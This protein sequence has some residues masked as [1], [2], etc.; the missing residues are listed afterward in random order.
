MCSVYSLFVPFSQAALI[1]ML[2]SN[3]VLQ[4]RL[5]LWLASLL[6]VLN[7]LL[8]PRAQGHWGSQTSCACPEAPATR[9]A[10]TRRPQTSASQGQMP[11]IL[12]RA[13]SRAQ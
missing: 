5:G 4:S 7:S 2:H 6:S 11:S 10:L 12:W 9:R 3:L 8:G 1:G 13:T